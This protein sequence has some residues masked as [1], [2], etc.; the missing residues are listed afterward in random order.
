MS[1]RPS[2]STSSIKVRR[3]ILLASASSWKSRGSYATLAPDEEDETT[4]FL[5]AEDEADVVGCAEDVGRSWSGS[6]GVLVVDV[7]AAPP[8]PALLR[9]NPSPMMFEVYRKEVNER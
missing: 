3:G 6:A 8:P 4:G 9:V 5:L 7:D 2:N 1:L